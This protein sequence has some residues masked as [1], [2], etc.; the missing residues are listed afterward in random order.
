MAVAFVTSWKNETPASTV[1]ITVSPAAN[2][3]LIAITATDAA[4]GTTT[5]GGTP[6]SPLT[7]NDQFDC[8]VDGQHSA[9]ASGKAVGNETAITFTN[10]GA[11]VIGLI[12][13]FSG[14]DTTTPND[15][16]RVAVTDNSSGL[17]VAGSITTAT[18]GAMMVFAFALDQS[19][20]TN[21]TVTVADTSLA[22][23]TVVQANEP[24]GFRHVFIAYAIKATAG[25]TTITAT[26]T[27]AAGGGG[28]IYASRPASGVTAPILPKMLF[29]LP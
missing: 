21:P 10:D 24:G 20:T 29:I 19:T 13:S 27:Q 5:T 17:T 26:T 22:T 28:S 6:A 18:N 2:D 16:T 1:S 3:F 23:W 8:T 15:V 4:T 25:A 12:A 11:T 14:V 9:T 7:I